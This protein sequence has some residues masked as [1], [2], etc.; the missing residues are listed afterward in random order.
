MAM[1]TIAWA[2]FSLHGGEK[3]LYNIYWL[4]STDWVKCMNMS[5]RGHR[6]EELKTLE[7]QR[8]MWLP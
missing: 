6:L 4:I 1:A 5:A 8:C 2:A 7:M 3:F